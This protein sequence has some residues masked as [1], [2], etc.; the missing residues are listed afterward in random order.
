[1]L[2]KGGEFFYYMDHI[3]AL[4]W[5]REGLVGLS[6]HQKESLNSQIAVSLLYV[7]AL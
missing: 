5:N 7:V 1:M 3:L 4:T 2:I 6:Q